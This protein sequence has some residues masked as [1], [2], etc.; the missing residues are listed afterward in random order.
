MWPT[1]S[2]SEVDFTGLL[3]SAPSLHRTSEIGLSEVRFTNVVYAHKTPS[4]K[5]G[6][7]MDAK[8]PP[9]VEGELLALSEEDWAQASLRAQVFGPLELR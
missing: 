2:F 8:A 6:L 3:G 9:V 4:Q 1:L 7:G 5:L